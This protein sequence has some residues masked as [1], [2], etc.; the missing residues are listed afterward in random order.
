VILRRVNVNVREN[1]SFG[2]GR[3]F[4]AIFKTCI[5]YFQKVPFFTSTQNVH[6]K[7]IYFLAK[8]K[9][10]ILP[11]FRAKPTVLGVLVGSASQ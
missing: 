6:L 9:I 10:G 4:A 2:C 5:S 8:S 3:I 7:Y 11:I 1:I